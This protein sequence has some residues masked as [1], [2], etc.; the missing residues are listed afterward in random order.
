MNARVPSRLQCFVGGA[1]GV[2][3]FHGLIMGLGYSITRQDSAGI[4][5][6]LLMGVGLPIGVALFRSVHAEAFGRVYLWGLLLLSAISLVLFITGRTPPGVRT[7]VWSDGA[8]L[9]VAIG[10][11]ALMHFQRVSSNET[12]SGPEP[13]TAPTQPRL[14]VSHEL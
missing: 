13:S 7:A 5:I 9:A 8:H 4:V 2:V 1:I 10:L 6:G 11:L 3:G 14:D 12:G